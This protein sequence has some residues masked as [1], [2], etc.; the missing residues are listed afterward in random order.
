[1][2]IIQSSTEKNEPKYETITFGQAVD[3]VLKG[4]QTVQYGLPE[5][6]AGEWVTMLPCHSWRIDTVAPYAFRRQIQPKK[7]LVP[8][9]FE[10]FPRG[11]WIR[12]GGADLCPCT[13]TQQYAGGYSYENLLKNFKLLVIENGRVVGEKPCGSEVQE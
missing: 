8:F 10:T 1:M 6:S 7:K 11:A 3:A 9:T 2:K 4:D 12:G 5:W 13:I